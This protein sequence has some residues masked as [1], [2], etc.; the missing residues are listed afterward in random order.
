M[1]PQGDEQEPDGDE[2]EPSLG[3]TDNIVQLFWAAGDS[4]DLESGD[5]ADLEMN[6]DEQDYV[7]TLDEHSAIFTMCNGISHPMG[8]AYV[9][10]DGSLQ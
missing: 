8:T 5:E 3:S 2:A 9:R 4:A 1:E 6:G 7:Q 10:P